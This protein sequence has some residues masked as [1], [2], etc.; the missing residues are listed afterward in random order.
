MDLHKEADIQVCMA[1]IQVCMEGTL[2]HM[3]QH[4]EEHIRVCKALDKQ[5]CMEEDKRVC[6]ARILARRVG[7]SHR[8]SD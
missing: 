1:G 8:Y 3:A 6:K 2:V 4:M 5:A 7:C